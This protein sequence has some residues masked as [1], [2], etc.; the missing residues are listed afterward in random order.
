MPYVTIMEWAADWPTHLKID[1]AIND[2][3]GDG[4]IDGHVLHLAGPSD[5]GVRVVDVWETRDHAV[6]FKDEY[7]EPAVR[8]LGLEPGPPD[9]LT[10]FDVEIVRT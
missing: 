3:V 4:V 9:T 10:E 5:V 7:A 6:R 2:A 1:A 8:S